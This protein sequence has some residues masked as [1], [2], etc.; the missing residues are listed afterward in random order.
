[1]LIFEGGIQYYFSLS[2]IFDTVVCQ[3]LTGFNNCSPE[4]LKAKQWFLTRVIL[5]PWG[6]LAMSGDILNCHDWGRGT[7]GI[8]K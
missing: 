6:H 2:L 3:R 1:M 4:E 8:N 7:S 5:F